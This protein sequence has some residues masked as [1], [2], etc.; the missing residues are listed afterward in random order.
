V[1]SN[2]NDLLHEIL[3]LSRVSEAISQSWTQNPMIAAA[4]THSDG[5]LWGS[6]RASL[7]DCQ[8]TLGKLNKKLD[9]LQ[10]GSVFA[11]GFLRKPTKLIKLN[12]NMG[13][14]LLFKQQIHSYNNAMQSALQMINV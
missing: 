3:G 4:E 7:D 10:N 14:I 2:V 8:S 1:D 9:E 6:V 5:N 12:M 13:D 11:R